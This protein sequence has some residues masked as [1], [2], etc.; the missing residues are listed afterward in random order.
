MAELRPHYNNS[1][2]VNIPWET[3]QDENLSFLARGVLLDALSRPAGW[4]FSIERMARSCKAKVKGAGREAVAAACRELE[5]AGYRRGTS[6]RGEGGRIRR[7]ADVAF[8]P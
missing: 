5:D 8:R 4:D 1:G 7:F 3:A 2:S 6:E